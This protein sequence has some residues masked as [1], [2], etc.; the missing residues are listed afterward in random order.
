[1]PLS[2]S[3]W[4]SHFRGRSFCIYLALMQVGKL[5][6]FRIFIQNIRLISSFRNEHFQ[7]RDFNTVLQM[8]WIKVHIFSILKTSNHNPFQFTS[9]LYPET[10]CQS[11]GR[12]CLLLISSFPYNYIYKKDVCFLIQEN[13]QALWWS[14]AVLFT[15]GSIRYR[16]HTPL[17]FFN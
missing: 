4:C 17:R 10:W 9:S 5:I 15:L 7:V 12:G 11:L 1:M 13:Q 2:P 16:K 14:Y 8:W 3:N 6:F